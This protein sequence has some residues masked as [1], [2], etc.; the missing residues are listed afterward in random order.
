MKQLL[1]IIVFTFS[2]I[3]SYAQLEDSFYEIT[4]DD[5]FGMQHLII[6][7][8][9]NH[10][11]IWKVGSP[12]KSIF[13]CAYSL[14]HV[15]VTDTINSYP[16]NDTSVFIIKNVAYGQGYEWPHTVMLAGRYFVN[17]DTLID[18][19]KIEFSPDNGNLWL[20][21][22]D[23]ILI[24]TT[25]NY[26]WYWNMYGSPKPILTGNSNGW[27]YFEINLAS[28]GHA[29][30]VHDGDTVL[31]RFSFISDSIQTYKDGLMYDNLHFEDWVEGIEENNYNFCS[32]VPNPAN[33]KIIFNTQKSFANQTIKIY[34]S[35]GQILYMNTN[36]QNEEI[37][38][39]NFRN[40][41][42]FLINSNEQNQSIYK[43]II[44]H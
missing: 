25:Y 41:V 14:P 30:G 8:T 26:Y 28:V 37:N 7:S 40:G 3:I 39:T 22:F 21:L 11:N 23:S 19:G 34:N 32:L 43:L 42:Y 33:D 38:T 13:T 31:F 6:D 24:D 36:Y 9:N 20:N 27:K 5:G 16:I 12:N 2:G 35:L 4:F 1:L 10:N 17:S 29:F 15:I 44:Q 18:Y